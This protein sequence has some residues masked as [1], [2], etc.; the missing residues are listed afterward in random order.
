MSDI[1][2]A[3]RYIREQ[4]K[5]S[6]QQMAD[7]LNM[8]QGNYARLERGKIGLST[9]NLFKIA[10]IFDM[11]AMELMHYDPEVE[12]IPKEE[13]M[14]KELEDLLRKMD[15]LKSVFLNNLL[16][17]FRQ[18][19]TKY[20]P[21]PVVT[22][23][24]VLKLGWKLEDYNPMDAGPDH[25]MYSKK[26]MDKCYAA[27]F[28]QVRDFLVFFEL[29]LVDNPYFKKAYEEYKQKQKDEAAPEQ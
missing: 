22:Q 11:G 4:K 15:E 24:D 14:A 7:R 1:Y 23:E 5:L 19:R 21:V 2:K 17:N 12:K 20:S 25:V 27:T 16:K 8:S 18:E 13:R 28:E 29:G 9:E 6:Q 10:D 26:D 3:I